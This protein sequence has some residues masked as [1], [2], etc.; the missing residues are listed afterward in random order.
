MLGAPKKEKKRGQKRKKNLTNETLFSWLPLYHSSVKGIFQVL[1]CL[2]KE[3]EEWEKELR[4]N[5]F[6]YKIFYFEGCDNKVQEE[7]KKLFMNPL[8]VSFGFNSS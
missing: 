4:G 6:A 8:K 1:C 3:E 7:E 5:E 2:K